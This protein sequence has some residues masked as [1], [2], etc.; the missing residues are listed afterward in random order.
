MN[1]QTFDM[2]MLASVA[3][4][5]I[6]VSGVLVAAVMAVIGVIGGMFIF[7]SRLN[8]E[9]LG[10]LQQANKEALEDLKQANKG[11]HDGIVHRIEGVEKHL[12]DDVKEVRGDV[13]EI[14]RRLPG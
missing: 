7:F 6:Q 11:A 8:R 3:R 9:R 1:S 10:E 13:K 14:L 4:L 12:R 2:D 5:L